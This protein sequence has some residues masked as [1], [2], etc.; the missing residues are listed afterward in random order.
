MSA[1]AG[2]RADPRRE[3]RAAA[4]VKVEARSRPE[5]T[6]VG[7]VAGAGKRLA[8]AAG[9]RLAAEAVEAAVGRLAAAHSLGILH[10]ASGE[11]ALVAL[12]TVNGPGRSRQPN[13]VSSPTA[14]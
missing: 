1:A 14:W 5:G 10:S 7:A 11:G 9:S 12:L 13:R 6:E 2:T 3:R 4:A 8:E